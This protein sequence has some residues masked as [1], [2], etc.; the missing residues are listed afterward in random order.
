MEA[1]VHEDNDGNAIEYSLDSGNNVI[2]NTITGFLSLVRPLDHEMERFLTFS[3]YAVDALLP[4]RTGTATVNITVVD[5]NDVRP[6]IGGINNITVSTGA[7]IN[8]FSSIT[9]SDSDTVGQIIRV[10]ITAV[11]DSLIPSPFSGRVCVDEYNVITKMTDVCGLP[12]GYLL[13]LQQMFT[14]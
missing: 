13:T 14:P 10:N 7:A 11:G 6:T 12:T 4:A 3:E 8:P 1:G 9:I 5:V 2:V